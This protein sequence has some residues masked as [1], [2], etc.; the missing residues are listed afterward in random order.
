MSTEEPTVLDG[1]ALMMN[2]PR[3]RQRRMDT[4]PLR[5]PGAPLTRVQGRQPGDATT[6]AELSDL[7]SSI[8]TIGVLQPVLAEEIEQPDGPPRIHLV[9]G[10]RRLRACRWG[11][12]HMPDN[13]HFAGLPAIICPGPLSEEERRT[14]AIVENLAREPLRPGEQAAALLWHRCAVLTGKLLRVGKPVPAEVNALQDPIERWEALERIRGQDPSCAAP[15]AEVL[16]RLGLQL[17]PRKARELVSAFRAL[18]TSLSEE[19]DEQKVRLYTR[20][21]FARLRAGREEAADQIW[22]AIKES[23]RTPLLT[24]AVQAATEDPDLSADEAITQAQHRRDE[25]DRSRSQALS[26]A[27]VGLP[28]ELAAAVDTALDAPAA[29]SDIATEPEDP[30]LVPPPT[31]VEQGQD[32]EQRLDATDTIRAL[33]ALA[34]ALRAGTTVDR[35]TRGSLL[36]L[37]DEI[38]DH[39]NQNEEADA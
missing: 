22:A 33:R 13:I 16:T 19:M 27:H 32:D 7:I 6:P 14:W 17:S 20:V 9:T 30:A 36:L 38:R 26:R 8:A 10:E 31:P 1:L 28:A 11:A 15:W 21:R 34:A 24:A 39:L 4:I 5:G 37:I 25:A 35:F 12:A 18:P 2:S 23:K 3:L 29:V